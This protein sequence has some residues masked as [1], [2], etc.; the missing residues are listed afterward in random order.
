MEEAT[1]RGRKPFTPP[2]KKKFVRISFPIGLKFE[3]IVKEDA[4]NVKQDCHGS[5]ALNAR[6]LVPRWREEL[7]FTIIQHRL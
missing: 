7:F 3:A 6:V 2:Q 4:G 1:K 5:I